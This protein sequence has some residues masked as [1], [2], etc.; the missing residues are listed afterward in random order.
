MFPGTAKTLWGQQ[1]YLA[2]YGE[3]GDRQTLSQALSPW[4][5]LVAPWGGQCFPSLCLLNQGT[6]TAQFFIGYFIYLHFKCCPFS[7]FPLHKPHPIPIPFPPHHSSIPLHWGI[8]P[9]QDQG[10]P[11]PLMPDKAILSSICSWS[12]RSHHVYSSV[13]GL[14]PGN[15]GWSG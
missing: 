11:L 6:F 10:L 12:H 7:Q 14:V 8:K 15:S 5:E 13:G 9:P 2:L 4:K 1:P 3:Q